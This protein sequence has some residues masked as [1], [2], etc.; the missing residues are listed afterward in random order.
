MY[1]RY[2]AL[3]TWPRESMSRNRG[4]ISS[5]NAIAPASEHPVEARDTLDLHP[6]LRVS[7]HLL[8]GGGGPACQL[9][10]HPPPR[11]HPGLKGGLPAA[12]GPPRG[13]PP[14]PVPPG[15]PSP[16]GAR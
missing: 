5:S 9:P 11:L 7:F 6:L 15:L 3:F 13:A 8:Y 16:P 10:V 2:T 1:V 14:H 4:V 12:G